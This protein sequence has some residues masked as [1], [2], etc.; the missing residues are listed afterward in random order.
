VH[1]DVRLEE[2]AYEQAEVVVRE[3]LPLIDPTST[4]ICAAL[5]ARDYG[6]GLRQSKDMAYQYVPQRGI[7]ASYAQPC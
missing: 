7:L 6:L 4:E 5:V 2:R 1:G 3:Q